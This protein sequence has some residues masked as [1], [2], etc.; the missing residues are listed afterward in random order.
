[1][2]DLEK[3]KELFVNAGYNEL[4]RDEFNDI[5]GDAKK[6]GHKEF[7]V[8]CIGKVMILAVGPGRTGDTDC[9]VNMNFSLEGK[10]IEHASMHENDD[11]D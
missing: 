1:M 9:F 4:D 6:M 3:M 7:T 10:F 2:T 5:E 11:E 8:A